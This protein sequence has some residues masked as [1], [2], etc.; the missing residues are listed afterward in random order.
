MHNLCRF[1]NGVEK[2]EPMYQN[3]F[4]IVVVKLCYS[5]GYLIAYANEF[6]Q[7]PL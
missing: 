2:Y 7:L 3:R 5:V 1:L 4:E 6:G